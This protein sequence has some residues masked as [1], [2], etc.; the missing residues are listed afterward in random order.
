MNRRMTKP[1]KDLILS[2]TV[3]A[4]C[5]YLHGLF[6]IYSDAC[7]TLLVLNVDMRSTTITSPCSKG[8]HFLLQRN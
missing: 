7:F 8:S 1:V 4:C 5:K 2:L 6:L 3:F